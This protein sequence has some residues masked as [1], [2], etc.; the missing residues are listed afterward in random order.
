MAQPLVNL[1]FGAGDVRRA[2]KTAADV[3]PLRIIDQRGIGAGDAGERG[4]LAG[5]VH[6]H[7]DHSVALVA[8]GEQ[9]ERQ[10]D[11]VVEIARRCQHRI[12]AELGAQHGGQH[13]LH[14]GFATGAG[15]A[16]HLRVHRPP[17]R[18]RQRLQRRQ[19]VG[20]RKAA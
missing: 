15:D 7:F 18:R 12:G 4:Q 3:R 6:A 20:H 11:V 9:G 19:R 5:V 8:Q 1:A 16:E 14:G 17:P 2:V 13:F 10:A